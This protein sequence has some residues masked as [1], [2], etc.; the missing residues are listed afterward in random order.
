VYQFGVYKLDP[1]GREIFREAES[2]ALSARAFD[3][4]VYLIKHRDRAVGRDELIAA[5]WGKANVSDTQLNFTLFKARRAIGDRGDASEAIRTVQRFGYRWVAPIVVDVEGPRG[6]LPAEEPVAPAAAPAT[7]D[8]TSIVSNTDPTLVLDVRSGRSGMLNLRGFIGGTL[9]ALLLGGMYLLLRN[10]PGPVVSSSQ[11]HPTDEVAPKMEP[12]I[13]LVAVLPAR[14]ASDD[15]WAWLHLGLMELISNHL[16]SANQAVVPSNNMV[17]LDRGE[18]SLDAFAATVEEVTGAQTIVRPSAL[19]VDAAWT[20]R[21]NWQRPG[22]SGNVEAHAA[23]VVVAA[24][25]AADRLL[26]ALGE[27]ASPKERMDSDE[28]AWRAQVDGALLS[29]DLDE[30]R[31]L[32]DSRPSVSQ[33]TPDLQLIE[34]KLELAVGNADAARARLMRLLPRLPSESA[35]LMRARALLELGSSLIDQGNGADAEPVYAEAVPLLEASGNADLVARGYNGRGGAHALVG[36]I[37][38]ATGDFGRARIAYSTVGN[39]LG[40]AGV[41]YNEGLLYVLEHRPTEAL[42]LLK[43]AVERLKSVGSS[44][45]LADAQYCLANTRVGLLQAAESLDDTTKAMTSIDRVGDARRRTKLEYIHAR[46]L[47]ANGR[48]GEARTLFGTLATSSAAETTS[49]RGLAQG[50]LAVMEFNAG[51]MEEA[52]ATAQNAVANIHDADNSYSRAYVWLTGIRARR[53]LQHQAEASSETQALARWAETVPDEAVHAVGHV[54]EAEQA[55]ANRDFVN[56]IRL[57]EAALQE[58]KRVNSPS[59]I[60]SVVDSYAKALIASGRLD[61]AVAVAGQVSRWARIDFTCALLQVRLYRALNQP[62]AWQAALDHARTLAGE[63]SIPPELASL[64]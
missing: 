3:C 56:A 33:S 24:R 10:V 14:V 49:W 50:S 6:A 39:A 44:N 29:G 27:S 26:H 7:L 31:R 54:A 47:A 40:M 36:R 21:L 19:K 23:D 11:I 4:I 61:E 42:P 18:G 53:A 46:T 22:K 13:H 48:L 37:D 25:S 51:Q 59:T 60:A 16:R 9:I 32:V 43:N 38:D 1:A 17:A 55:W 12:N 52:L 63:R 64:R 34:A 2:V 15:D 41:E 30:V 57:H 28:D 62:V 5:V 45:Q 20:V 8:V 35:P 58:A